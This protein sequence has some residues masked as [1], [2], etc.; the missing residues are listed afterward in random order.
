MHS[1]F[2]NYTAHR[3]RRRLPYPGAVVLGT[4]V[5]FPA[6]TI[7]PSD[8]GH[9]ELL[10]IDL[11]GLVFHH[12]PSASTLRQSD[13]IPQAARNPEKRRS[14]R[15][16]SR[17][18]GRKAQAGAACHTASRRYICHKTQLGVFA[19]TTSARGRR[20]RVESRLRIDD[21]MLQ[22]KDGSTGDLELSPLP[23]GATLRRENT[24]LEQRRRHQVPQS[25]HV[26]CL[27]SSQSC[28]DK[29]GLMS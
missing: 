11:Q 26:I 23:S 6:A 16:D 15:E 3:D 20:R 19:G 4:L 5:A 10:L 18:L 17:L 21:N 27:L 13:S 28:Q 2:S 22:R 1:F 29:L 14:F 9:E 7:D 8:K 12:A 25:K 24:G